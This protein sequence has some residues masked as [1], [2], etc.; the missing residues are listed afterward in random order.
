[1]RDR[2]EPMLESM[3]IRWPTGHAAA[4]R[5]LKS[6]LFQIFLVHV[7]YFLHLIL[8]T[9]KIALVLLNSEM[10]LMQKTWLP[11][12][13]TRTGRICQSSS[14]PRPLSASTAM[15]VQA[16]VSHCPDPM[17]YGKIRIHILVTEP[18]QSAVWKNQDRGLKLCKRVKL[19]N[20]SL[21]ESYIAPCI[22]GPG[23]CQWNK[24]T[25]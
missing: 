14:L 21:T 2:E 24:A 8:T 16:R 3:F 20:H 9:G 5:R 22:R 1:M 13:S 10:F 18:A 17:I 19:W 15:S 23:L 7:W 11:V 6:S 4:V 12:V 25:K